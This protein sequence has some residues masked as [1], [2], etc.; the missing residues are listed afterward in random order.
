MAK[1]ENIEDLN[2]VDQQQRLEVLRICAASFLEIRDFS[3][4][5]KYYLEILD[6]DP[7]NFDA[8][9]NLAMIDCKT[10]S[11]EELFDYY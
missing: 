6:I 10:N 4:A 9:L 5:N 2:N 11:I 7:D 8:Y 1:K 3:N